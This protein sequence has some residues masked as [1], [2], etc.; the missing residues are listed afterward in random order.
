MDSKI[1]ISMRTEWLSH[2]LF[3]YI[4]IYFCKTIES[5]LNTSAVPVI[6]VHG[7]AL[8]SRIA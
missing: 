6:A 1:K 2:V 5:K 3:I 8:C 4:F 7:L